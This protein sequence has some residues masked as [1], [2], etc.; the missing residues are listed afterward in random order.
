MV[1]SKPSW[2]RSLSLKLILWVGAITVIVIGVFAYVNLHSQQ[3]QLM[4]EAIVGAKQLS[5]TLTRSL[6]FDMLH[7]YREALYNSIETIGAQE[8]IE[9]IRIFNKVGAI[10]FSSDKEEMGQL[11][12][13]KA[14]ACY[15]C[16]AVDKPLERL[17]TPERS[18]IFR[19]NGHRLLGMITP[20]YNEPDCYNAACHYHPRDQRVLGV[21]DISLSLAAT[22][23]RIQEIKGKTMLF[24]VITILAIS[25]IIGLFVQRGVYRPVKELVAGT[26]RVASGDFD[27]TIPARSDD[28]IGQLA[29]SFN[30]MTQRL[31]KAD[32]EIKDLIKNLEKKV[33]KRTD[34]LK[35]VQYQLLQSE[36]LASIGKLAA[37]IAHEIN[38]PLNG[39]LTYTKLIERK[40][41]DGTLKKDEIPKFLSYLGIMERETERC[42]TIVRNLLD[43][44]RQREPSLKPDVDINAVVKEALSL[45]ANQI[46]LQEITLEKKFNQLPPIMADP[47]QLR[48]VFLNIILNACEAMNNEGVLTVTTALSNKRKK[49]VRVEIADSGVGI[50]EKDLPKIFDPFFTSKEKGTGLGLSVVYGIINSHQG[51]IEVDSKAG[52]GTTIT[53]TLPTEITAT[54]TNPSLETR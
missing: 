18:R 48:Q 12:D 50:D 39:I 31:K 35:A 29:E 37:T 28:E 34:E 40:L 33:T 16:H 1:I 49:A 47:M 32:G 54:E 3:K 7:N 30:T 2:Y 6:R 19:V 17:D 46:A 43:F 26:T 44:A 45:L 52:E 14:E 15:A 41:A 11:V 25:L 42:S 10:M 38:N 53:I 27:H 36:K 22:D 4:D 5:A 51:T 13:K 21:L 24:S 9:K 8:G 20:I 23:K